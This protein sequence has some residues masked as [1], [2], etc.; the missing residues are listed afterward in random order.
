MRLADGVLVAVDVPDDTVQQT[1]GG[2]DARQVKGSLK[3]ISS[4]LGSIGDNVVAAVDSLPPELSV[5][6]LDIAVGLSFEVEGNI[7]IAKL[8]GEAS[9]TI[10]MH[11]EAS[12]VRSSADTQPL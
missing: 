4:L 7:Y 6:N 9:L 10:T 5:I 8:G 1:F 12:K 3:Q 2:S 11:V